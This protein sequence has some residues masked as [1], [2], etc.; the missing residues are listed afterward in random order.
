MIA[1]DRPGAMVPWNGTPL[2]AFAAAALR[3]AIQ[4]LMRNRAN[5]FR[6]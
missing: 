1:T 4:T 6:Q 5:D 3:K 2:I